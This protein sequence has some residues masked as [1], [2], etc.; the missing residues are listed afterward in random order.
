MATRTVGN[1]KIQLDAVTNRFDRNMK[2]A[3]KRVTMFQR[4]AQK[5]RKIA[6]GLGRAFKFMAVAAA[7]AA[8]AIGGMLLKNMKTLDTLAKNASTLGIA[9]DKLS[10]LHMAAELTGTSLEKLNDGLAKMQRNISEANQGT[11]TAIDALEMLGLSAEKMINLSPH[12]QFYAIADALLQITN[13]SDRMSIAMDIFGRGGADLLNTLALG[14]EGLRAVQLEAEMLGGAFSEDDL[15]RVE[16]ANDAILKMK[17]AFGAV[18]K[19]LTIEL[20][21]TIETIAEQFKEMAISGDFKGINTIIEKMVNSFQSLLKNID[22]LKAGFGFVWSVIKGI[23]SGLIAAVGLAVTLVEVIATG[24]KPKD[25]NSVAYSVIKTAGAL[26]ESAMG[27]YQSS[28]DAANRAA[29]PN[30]TPNAPIMQ[31]G[32]T[33]EMMNFQEAL[34]IWRSIHRDGIALQVN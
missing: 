23:V 25:P 3:G 13:Q 4:T 28:R 6:V 17:V 8:V 21:P 1:L 31:N 26:G 27:S 11:G 22:A 14:A 19:R 2:N 10:G 29:F 24:R 15:A 16:A 34:E 18:V 5:A 30:M 33:R 12:E 20:S 32:E 9:S 7:G